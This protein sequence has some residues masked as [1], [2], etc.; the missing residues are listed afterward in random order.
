MKTLLYNTLSTII[1]IS[2]FIIS[3]VVNCLLVYDKW[4][5]DER[6]NTIELVIKNP[7]FFKIPED[8]HKAI[9]KYYADYSKITA[10]NVSTFDYGSSVLVAKNECLSRALSLIGNTLTQ[11][12][13]AYKPLTIGGLSH[14]ILAYAVGMEKYTN[15]EIEIYMNNLLKIT[16]AIPRNLPDKNTLVKR[17]INSILYYVDYAKII[18]DIDKRIDI[19]NHDEQTYYGKRFEDK[20]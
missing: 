19:I 6:L 12:F 18:Y 10:D 13:R 17:P 9:K 16:N 20:L 5:E 1:I 14:G 3:L 7:K 8:S 4:F 11:D 2:I 15:D